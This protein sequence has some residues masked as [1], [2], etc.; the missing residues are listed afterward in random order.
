ARV[1]K[2]QH[3]LTD[4]LNLDRR[5]L[6]LVGVLMLRGAQTLGELHT[7]TARLAEFAD[8]VDLESAVDRLISREP[9]ALAARLPRR[10]GQKEVRYGHLLGAEV[11]A[12]ASSEAVAALDAPLASGAV[13]DDRITALELTVEQLRAELDVL[14]ARFTDFEKQFQ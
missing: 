1:T 9:D 5:E 4:A 7:R 12:P 10:A 3:L 13:G 6:A 14:R 2:Y 11:A 8:L